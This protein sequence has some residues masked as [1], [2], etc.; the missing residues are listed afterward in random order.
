MSAFLIRLLHDNSKFLNGCNMCT[1]PSGGGGGRV[2]HLAGGR[3]GRE[4][5]PPS[6]WRGR[7]RGCIT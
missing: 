6:W 1:P 7:E 4:G 3:G 5:V 2:Y